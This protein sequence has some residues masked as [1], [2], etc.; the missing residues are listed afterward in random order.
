MTN[1][2]RATLSTFRD[3]TAVLFERRY[4][5]TADD[6]WEAVTSP[7]RLARWLGPVYG[8]LRA[9]GTYEL[10]MGEDLAG[11]A[12]N[13]VGEIRDCDAPQM[14][15]VTWRFPGEG[16]TFVIVSV[17]PEDDGALLELQHYGL[18]PA[19]ARGYAG[20]WHASLD[21][22]ADHVADVPVRSWQ[23]AFDAALPLY[24]DQAGGETGGGQPTVASS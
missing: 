5:T 14:F 13:A 23:E 2:V 4:A 11:A 10:R 19:G 12:E 21:Q 6:L 22:L 7:E 8:D 1:D 3:G 17:R 16:E 9:G 20:G 24:R 15:S 18:T